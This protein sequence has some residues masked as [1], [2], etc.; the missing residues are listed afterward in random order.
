MKRE[1]SNAWLL[2]LLICFLEIFSSSCIYNPAPDWTKA[3]TVHDVIQ[4]ES[5]RLLWVRSDV[6]IE[7]SWDSIRVVA[8]NGR[9]FIYGSLNINKSSSVISLDGLTGDLVWQTNPLPPSTLFANQDGFFVGEAGGGSR[10]LSFDLDSGKILWSRNFPNSSGV[11]SLFVYNGKLHA[12]LGT[13]KHII[14]NPINGK[15][16]IS[17]PTDSLPFY[18]SAECGEIFQPPVYMGDAIYFRNGRGLELGQVCSVDISSGKIIWRT[19]IVIVSNVVPTNTFLFFLEENGDLSAVNRK[20]GQV[21]PDKV[22]SFDNKPFILYD[23]RREV[24][25]YFLA[26]DAHSNVIYV[27]LGD[28]RQLFAFQESK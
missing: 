16:V 19:G 25:G 17:L 13:D 1:K 3:Y 26:S 6:Y 12:F 27:Y 10:I 7:T 28:S 14:L 15:K 11:E 21:V 8:S 24:G 9:V 2:I 4:N 20:T 23:A 5:W 22:I 18:G